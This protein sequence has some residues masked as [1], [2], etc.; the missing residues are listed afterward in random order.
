[1]EVRHGCEIKEITFGSS[2]DEF[3]RA[4]I[5]IYK[6]RPSKKCRYKGMTESTKYS[7]RNLN[8]PEELERTCQKDARWEIS[9]IST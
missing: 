3:F 2:T 9:R 7:R 1:M 4:I 5:R 6:I 8:I